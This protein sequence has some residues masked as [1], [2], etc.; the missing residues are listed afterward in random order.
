MIY[1]WLHLLLSVFTLF[2]GSFLDYITSFFIH[3]WTHN[4][5]SFK[6][7]LI[8]WLF[9]LK[10]LYNIVS[11]GLTI[12]LLFF[13]SELK[14]RFKLL[15]TNHNT[16]LETLLRLF[17]R[18]CKT[19]NF[20]MVSP[21]QKIGRKSVKNRDSF[22]LSA[23]PNTACIVLMTSGYKNLVSKTLGDTSPCYL[24]LSFF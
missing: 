23:N 5:Q 21:K 11:K 18:S 10:W 19:D 24:I 16:S 14:K 20:S 3:N 17:N 22:F 2:R 12:A 13:F 9:E 6:V 7:C 8:H 4:F 15:K 1:D